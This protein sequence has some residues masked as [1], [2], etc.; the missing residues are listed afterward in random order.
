MA[1]QFD[2]VLGV[3]Q[4]KLQRMMTDSGKAQARPAV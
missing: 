1:E 4:Q 3:Y 2:K